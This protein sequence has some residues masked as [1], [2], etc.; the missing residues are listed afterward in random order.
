MRV[1]IFGLG[2]LFF[3]SCGG[4]GFIL[5]MTIFHSKVEYRVTGFCIIASLFAFIYWLGAVAHALGIGVGH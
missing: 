1:V 4:L 2:L 5:P 3:G